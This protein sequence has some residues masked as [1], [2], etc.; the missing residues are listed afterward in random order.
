MAI[1]L[2]DYV[3]AASATFVCDTQNV[4]VI[5]RFSETIMQLSSGELL[6][7]YRGYDW[8]QTRS[9]YYE[10]ISHKTASLFE[11]ACESG[12]LLS[13]IDEASVQALRTYGY[14]IGMAFQIVDDILDAKD[15]SG[16]SADS[17][18]KDELHQKATYP[19]LH[20]LETSQTMAT[21]LVE[22]AIGQ[23]DFLGSRGEIL[24]GL[25]RFI[26]VR[27]F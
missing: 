1:L 26:S 17:T 5:R 8:T 16:M 25:G 13:G 12:A 6:E 14:N 4:R 7:Y 2:G 18:G 10:R 9:D 11:T 20:G 23:L 27:R 22:E 24:K 19:S 21:E 15:P 3:F